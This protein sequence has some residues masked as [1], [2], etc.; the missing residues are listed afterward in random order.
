VPYQCLHHRL[1]HRLYGSR[2]EAG[3]TPSRPIRV[4]KPRFETSQL[5]SVSAAL[6]SSYLRREA[7]LPQVARRRAD[8]QTP[9]PWY[10]KGRGMPT[11][12]ADRYDRTLED[13]FAVQ[14]EVTRSIVAAVAPQVEL[15]EVAHARHAS[16][17]SDAV[18]RLASPRPVL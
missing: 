5:P 3:S 2:N 4:L 16:P 13:V 18:A 6:E 15:A 11:T 1:H 14:E 7:D 12:G 8:D 10:R 17:N 9:G